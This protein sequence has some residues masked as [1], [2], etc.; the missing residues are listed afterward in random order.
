VGCQYGKTANKDNLLKS[1]FTSS[2]A[3]QKI[4][5][6]EGVGIFKIIKI[7]ERPDARDYEHRYLTRCYTMLGKDNF[8]RILYNRTTNP[9]IILDNSMVRSIIEKRTRSYSE[10]K[11]IQPI[12]PNWKGKSRSESMRKKLSNTLMGHSV[13]EDVRFKIRAKLL[14]RNRSADTIMKT[15]ASRFENPNNHYLFISPGQKQYHIV[16]GNSYAKLKELGL[17]SEKRNFVDRLNTYCPVDARNSKNFEWTFFR[18]RDI[19]E[20]VLRAVDPSSIIKHY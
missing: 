5:K 12:P 13:S 19:I 14:G 6:L 10:G 17:A 15:K 20:D 11:Y 4:I 9:A 16:V 18:G 3:I 2:K 8:V 1:Y 7:V